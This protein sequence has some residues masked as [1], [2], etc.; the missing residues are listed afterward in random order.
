MTEFIMVFIT[1]PKE[2][3]AQRIARDIISSRLAGCVNIIKDMRSIYRWRGKIEDESEVLMIVKT[4]LDLFEELKKRVKDL[5]SYSV[6]EIIALPVIEGS[7]EY[8]AWL[9]EETG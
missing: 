7:E 1:A 5:H 8:L 2:E 6:P 4:R 9:K 3:E